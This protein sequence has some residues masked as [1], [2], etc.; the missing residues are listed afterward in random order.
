[1]GARAIAFILLI[2]AVIILLLSPRL[3]QIYDDIMRWLN[4]RDEDDDINNYTE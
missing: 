3:D 4:P 1:M 2:T